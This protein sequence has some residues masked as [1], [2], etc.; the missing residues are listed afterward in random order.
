MAA[1]LPH[2]AVRL[3]GS[4]HWVP[5]DVP[6]TLAILGG[7]GDLSHKKLLPALYNLNLDGA[8]GPKFAIVGFS[9]EQLNDQTYRQFAHD[10]IETF[11]RRALTE[12]DWSKFAPLLHFVSGS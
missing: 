5:Q 9:L 10:G 2:N 12:A 7:A 1:I 6:C 3:P 8:L 11:S 4:F